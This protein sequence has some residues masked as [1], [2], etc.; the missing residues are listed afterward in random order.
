MKL[1]NKFLRNSKLKKIHSNLKS[2]TLAKILPLEAHLPTKFHPHNP[3]N[4]QHKLVAKHRSLPT[5]I[6]FLAADV[7][8]GQLG[9][10]ERL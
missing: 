10:S 1:L 6:V 3:S 9:R 7:T 5:L 8:R 2:N 4:S